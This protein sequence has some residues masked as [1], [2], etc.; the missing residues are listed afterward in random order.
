[1]VYTVQ[2][3]EELFWEETKSIY[4]VIETIYNNNEAIVAVQ[5]LESN[6]NKVVVKQRKMGYTLPKFIEADIFVPKGLFYFKLW[7]LKKRNNSDA[8]KQQ[9]DK[10]GNLGGEEG[11][12]RCEWGRFHRMWSKTKDASEVFMPQGTAQGVE[13][14]RITEAEHV[15]FLESFRPSDPNFRWN[16]DKYDELIA[17]LKRSGPQGR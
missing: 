7:T 5:G 10:E 6:E 4:H 1:M 17:S 13:L 9:V 8:K 14:K 16:I 12:M 11:K 2:V 15:A 3:Q